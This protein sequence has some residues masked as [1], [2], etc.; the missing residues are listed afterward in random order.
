MDDKTGLWVV[1]EALRRV[2]RNK[3]QVAAYAVS[4]VQEEIG[5][6]GAQTSSFSVDPHVGI[7]V[8]V[9]T[10][11][12]AQPWKRKRKAISALALARSFIAGRT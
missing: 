9:T 4:T 10:Q 2:D 3:L 11:P 1:M 6:R 5:L 8:D 12:T 7:A